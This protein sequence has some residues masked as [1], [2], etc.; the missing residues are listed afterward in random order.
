MVADFQESK[1]EIA[2]WPGAGRRWPQRGAL[3]R[4]AR[5]SRL[6]SLIAAA[7]LSNDLVLPNDLVHGT[8]DDLGVGR[9][10][11]PPGRLT[12]APQAFRLS[13]RPPARM[14]LAAP[15]VT[16]VPGT[17]GGTESFAS[18]RLWRP[19]RDR[20]SRSSTTAAIETPSPR[21]GRSVRAFSSSSRTNRPHLASEIA[22]ANRRFVTIP[23]MPE[24]LDV[25][26]LVLAIADR[27]NQAARVA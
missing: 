3:P 18:Q 13:A 10:Q 25:D 11:P 16:I 15:V 1:V 24:I 22:R 26:R 6:L 21:F 4:R 9:D 14:F 20:P 7:L 19:L 23:T 2:F 12:P 17:T 8:W 5:R 27:T